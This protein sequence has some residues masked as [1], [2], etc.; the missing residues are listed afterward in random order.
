V[1]KNF[2]KLEND[3]K[4]LLFGQPLVKKDLI[5]SLKVHLDSNLDQPPKALVLSLHGNTGIL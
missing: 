4:K 1:T 3:L 2:T 5:N